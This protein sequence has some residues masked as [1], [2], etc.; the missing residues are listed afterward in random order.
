[1]FKKTIQVILLLCLCNQAIAQPTP[2]FTGIG[3]VASATIHQKL[4]IYVP[5]G[6]T[7]PAPVVMFIHGGGWVS[8]G[9]GAPN[10]PYFEPS[11]N[12]GFICVDINYTPSS[13]K[14]WPAQIEDCKAAVR[15][16]NANAT[17]YNMDTCRIAVMG[18]SAG[19]HLAAVMGTSANVSALEGAQLAIIM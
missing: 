19:G 6:L 16:L 12:A 18:S 14:K 5:A 17:T 7:K 8:G 15:F 10:V 9:K 4:D 11:Y 1:M 13:V 3:Y 2:S